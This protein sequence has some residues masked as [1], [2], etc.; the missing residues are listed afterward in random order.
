L[1]GLVLAAGGSRRFGA[2]KQLIDWHGKPLVCHAV[3][4]SLAVCGAGVT[5]VTGAAAQQVEACLTNWPVQ[6]VCNPAWQSG[7]AGSLQ[8]GIAALRRPAIEGLLILLCDQPLVRASEL[9]SMVDVWQTA[10]HQPVAANYNNVAGAP[11]IFP[12]ACL[13]LFDGLTGD[14]GARAL[15]NDGLNCHYVAMPAAAHDIDTADDLER[16]R[17]ANPAPTRS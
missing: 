8:A 15:L 11:A 16:V 10:P 1:A 5:V 6:I 17:A 2:P 9:A 13:E 7:M 12:A 3:A 14:Q 4:S